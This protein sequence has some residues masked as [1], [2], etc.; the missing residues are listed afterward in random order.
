MLG[1]APNLIS[2][3]N[4]HFSITDFAHLLQLFHL[5]PNPLFEW[6]FADLYLVLARGGPPSLRLRRQRSLGLSSYSP[7]Q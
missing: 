2:P 5:H 6:E 3:T 4:V 1:V 7:E